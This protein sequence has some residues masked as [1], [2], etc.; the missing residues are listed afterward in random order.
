MDYVKGVVVSLLSDI[1]FKSFILHSRI[2]M[3]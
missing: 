3:D 1:H 2:E